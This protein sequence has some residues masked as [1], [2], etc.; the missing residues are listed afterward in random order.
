MARNIKTITVGGDY[1]I[2]FKIL[3]KEA[4][5]YMRKKILF[6][7]SF[8]LIGG[9]FIY[10]NSQATIFD[11]SPLTPVTN[12]IG[13]GYSI[14]FTL[15]DAENDPMIVSLFYNTQPSLNGATYIASSTN[16]LYN[17]THSQ[18]WN[19]PSQPGAYFIIGTVIGI[20][21]N[22]NMSVNYSACPIL[23]VPNQSI[24]PAPQLSAPANGSTVFTKRPTF[25]WNSVSDP[26]GIKEYQIVIDNGAAYNVTTTNYTPTYDLSLGTHTWKVRALD[27]LNNY[28]NWSD[29]WSVTIAEKDFTM[30]PE[31]IDIS[32]GTIMIINYQAE[33]N[34][35]VTFKITPTNNTR[36]LRTLIGS[37]GIATW[38]GKDSNGKYLKNGYYK[39]NMYENSIFI[40]YKICGVQK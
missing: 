23:Y 28:G 40:K 6:L 3:I 34:A 17:G 1:L 16:Y 39:M 36:V 24:P 37:N 14:S 30:N 31:V 11:I 33:P 29:T 13:Q 4:T 38:D 8:L 2:S 5:D 21:S 18:Y 32:E 35:T 20:V 26:D 25:I 22:T 9:T 12:V 27:N 19:G 10:A 7:I 15:Y